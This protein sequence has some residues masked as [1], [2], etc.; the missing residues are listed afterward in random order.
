MSRY[1]VIA[2]NIIRHH[3]D[4]PLEEVYRALAE[5][6][7]C[8]KCL[9]QRSEEQ[10]EVHFGRPRGVDAETWKNFG[11]AQP[12]THDEALDKV[13]TTYAWF[14]KATTR[15][16]AAITRVDWSP[17]G[18]ASEPVLDAIATLRIIFPRPF[19]LPAG[20]HLLLRD[21]PITVGRNRQP[22]MDRYRP[23]IDAI[24]AELKRFE[25]K[26]SDLLDAGVAVRLSNLQT[27]PHPRPLDETDWT[28]VALAR[29]IDVDASTLR[30]WGAALPDYSAKAKSA[31]LTRGD[32]EGLADGALRAG[33]V[34]RAGRLRAL[35]RI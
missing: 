9:I 25:Q 7:A 23:R 2:N 19:L 17:T 22:N 35:A 10:I 26:V 4:N 30:R 16:V 18:L 34:T 1:E 13:R 5:V 8:V 33:N 15:T 3:A 32:L 31:L 12:L 11:P 14:D 29:A 6:G 20:D 24:V 27:G 28:K 21:S